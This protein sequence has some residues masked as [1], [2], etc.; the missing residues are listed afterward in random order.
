MKGVDSTLWGFSKLLLVHV[1]VIV[2][3]FYISILSINGGDKQQPMMIGFT[4]V[5]FIT[6]Q[7]YFISV[8]VRVS[9]FLLTQSNPAKYQ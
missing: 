7:L 5:V 1:I 2:R 8:Y 9:I 6:G 3:C 4:E